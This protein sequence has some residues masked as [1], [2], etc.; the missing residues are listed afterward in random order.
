M[1]IAVLGPLSVDGDMS[2]L[3]RRDR[4]VLEALVVRSGEVMSADRLADALWGEHLP[5]SW[6]KVLQGCIVRLPKRLDDPAFEVGWVPET[7][8][9]ADFLAA[10]RLWRWARRMAGLPT[11]DVPADGAG[12]HAA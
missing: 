12:G 7:V 8:T 6:T 5:P 4:V 10:L 3:R 9:L 2:L 1:A 11:G